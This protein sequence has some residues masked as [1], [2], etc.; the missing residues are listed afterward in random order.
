MRAGRRHDGDRGVRYRS[1]G[2][3]TAVVLPLL[4]VGDACVPRLRRPPAGRRDERYG[5]DVVDRRRGHAALHRRARL[6]GGSRRPSPCI[7]PRHDAGV[8]VAVHGLTSE[9]RRR[10]G[11]AGAPALRR[12][13]RR[14]RVRPAEGAGDRVNMAP[15]PAILGAAVIDSFEDWLRNHLLPALILAVGS[16]LLVRLIHWGARRWEADVDGRIHTAVDRGDVAA[17]QL[18]RTRALVQATSWALTALVVVVATSLSILVVG[19]PLTTL[20]APATVAG[21][22]VGFGAQQ[23]V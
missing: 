20:I 17:E 21:V 23:V 13:D 14:R 22:A 10:A 12:Q 5:E 8:G 9:R 6:P 7:D 11:A 19:V 1:G 4:R 18:K 16:V 15:S 2:V 3:V